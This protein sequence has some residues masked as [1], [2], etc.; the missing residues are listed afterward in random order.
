M[1]FDN[2]YIGKIPIPKV[3]RLEQK[4]II[5]LVDNIPILSITTAP[6]YLN[7]YLKQAQVNEYEHM[8][9]MLVYKLYGLT[10]NEIKIIDEFGNSKK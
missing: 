3:S 10:E 5:K 9:D 7:D 8:I 4:P 1:H 2:Y 6:D